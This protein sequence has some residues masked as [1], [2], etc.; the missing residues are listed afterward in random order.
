VDD[1]GGRHAA[2]RDGGRADVV[3]LERRQGRFEGLT[4]DYLTVHLPTAADRPPARFAAR[5]RRA[6]L[7]LFA[8]P[9]AA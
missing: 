2:R 8:D 6:G 9:F 1:K 7:A 4:E 5:L 3:L